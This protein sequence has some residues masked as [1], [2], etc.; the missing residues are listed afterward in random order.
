MKTSKTMKKIILLS[1]LA[2]PLCLL[3]TCCDFGSNSDV[4][5]NTYPPAEITAHSALCGAEVEKLNKEIYYGELGVCW[6]TSPNPTYIEDTP[7]SSESNHIG[8]SEFQQPFSGRISHLSPNTKYYVRAYLKNLSNQEIYYGEA[9]SF[10]TASSGSDTP[11][12]G[13]LSGKFTVAM[14]E[15]V[16]FSKGNLQYHPVLDQWRFAENQWDI[17]GE[18]NSNT[19][20]SYNGWIDLFG[21]RTSGYNNIQP[22][23]TA[24]IST[25]YG[26]LTAN[27]AGTNYDWGVFNA[28]SNGGNRIGL[29]RTLEWSEIE[30]ILDKRQT[31]SGCRFALA[32]VNN[33]DGLIL[34]PDDW[35]TSYYSLNNVN[36]TG[37]TSEIPTEFAANT[38]SQSDW[39][40]RLENHGAVFLPAAGVRVGNDTHDYSCGNPGAKGRYWTS[41]WYASDRAVSLYF[42][43]NLVRWNDFPYVSTGLSVRLVRNVD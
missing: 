21:W 28:I 31:S 23:E 29:W 35:N 14:G 19:S 3:F 16:C 34:L 33:V 18:E 4:K 7:N 26:P 20:A 9:K 2:F 27:M 39:N 12:E 25:Y 41:T 5:I 40:N 22:F 24:T 15:Q 13:S 36:V 37:G 30:Y 10:K 43:K 38:I 6:S 32:K 11:V 8:T 1:V 17:I 42:M